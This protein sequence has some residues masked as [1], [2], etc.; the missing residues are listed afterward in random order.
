MLLSLALLAVIVIITIMLTF[1]GLWSAGIMLIN[2]IVSALI[3]MTFWEPMAGL[4]VGFN[5][6]TTYW[7]DFFCLLSIFAVSLMI[8]RTI[9]DKMSKVHVEFPP[10]LDRLGGGFFG[11]WTG[12][13]FVCFLTAALQT[14]PLAKNFFFGGFQPGQAY[15]FNVLQP[16]LYWLGFTQKM[17]IGPLA[18]LTGGPVFDPKAEFIVKYAQRRADYASPESVAA[19]M[20]GVYTIQPE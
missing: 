18:P 17:S 11:I 9:T 3:A 12:W 6:G 4:F 10:L 20:S 1:E 5:Y 15:F 14:A 19:G 16:D 2:V 13:V 8:L 7:V